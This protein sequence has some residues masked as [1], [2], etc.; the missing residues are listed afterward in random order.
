MANGTPRSV[1]IRPA[2]V[3]GDVDQRRR[4]IRRSTSESA[5][6]APLAYEP[7]ST[8]RRGSNLATIPAT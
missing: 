5:V 4:V 1:R 2:A 7:N 3:S 6:G 8:T